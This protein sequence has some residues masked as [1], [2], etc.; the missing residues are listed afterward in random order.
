MRSAIALLHCPASLLL[1]KKFGSAPI[2]T[3]VLLVAIPQQIRC[4]RGH[5]GP[6]FARRRSDAMLFAVYNK[7][8]SRHPLSARPYRAPGESA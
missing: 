7:A 6:P 3:G 2:A 4:K 8:R 1:Q 5:M